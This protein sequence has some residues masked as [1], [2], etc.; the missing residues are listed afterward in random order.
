MVCD[1]GTTNVSVV[2]SLGVTHSKPYFMVNN[3]KIFVFYDP[4]HLFKSVPNNLLDGY[5]KYS[6]SDKNSFSG[7]F[8][9]T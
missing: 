1:Q 5:F 2:K 6:N 7:Y 8:W 3:E 9:N 4:P